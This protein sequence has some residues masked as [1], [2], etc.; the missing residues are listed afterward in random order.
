M[1]VQSYTP[2]VLKVTPSAVEKVKHLMDEEGNKDLCLRVY[3][4]GGGCSGFQYGFSFDDQIADD[5]SVI[6]KDGVKVLL[7]ALSYQYLAGSEVNYE[8]G[9]QGSRFVIQ[10]PNAKTTCGC[11]LSFSV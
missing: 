4:T 2:A 6:E 1:T 11:G 9:L 10:N 8:E 5:D 7:D 3:V